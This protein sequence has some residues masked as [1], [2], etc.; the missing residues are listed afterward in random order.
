MYIHYMYIQDCYETNKFVHFIE[1]IK[2]RGFVYKQVE[3][4]TVRAKDVKQH[5]LEYDSEHFDVNDSFVQELNDKYLHLTNS[6]IPQVKELFFVPNLLQDVWNLKTYFE[7]KPQAKDFRDDPK[8]G[9]I[10]EFHT[11]LNEQLDFNIKKINANK[12]KYITIEIFKQK[13]DFKFENDTI[14]ISGFKP[15][16][17]KTLIKQYKLAFNYRG[18]NEL[19][20]ETNYD[21]EKLLFKMMK[22]TFGGI[23]EKPERVRVGGGERQYKYK[24]DFETDTF[25]MMRKLMKFQSV[26]KATISS[27]INNRKMRELFMSDCPDL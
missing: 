27:E 12:M 20:V 22:Q 21:A 1:L 4:A 3:K 2:S 7:F 23:F 14:N 6:Q 24:L 25:K 17:M 11:Q 26:N 13:T 18:K 19:K 9:M 8:K 5:C 10:K 15:E 16:D